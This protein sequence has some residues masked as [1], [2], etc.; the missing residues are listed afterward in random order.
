MTAVNISAATTAALTIV[1]PNGG[2]NWEA[3]SAYGP[4]YQIPTLPLL[5]IAVAFAAQRWPF[6]FKVLTVVSSA[7]MF[8]VTAHTPSVQETLPVPLANALGAFS[9]GRLD[10]P[11]LGIALGLPG[12][13]S[14]LP[15]F[16]I[17]ASL[18]LW[19]HILLRAARETTQEVAP[20]RATTT[21]SCMRNRK[22]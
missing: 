17:E 9:A 7:L 20:A 6:I 22:R 13:A 12:L 14:L 19:L 4:R 5:M 18:L 8:I 16:V 10:Q 3:G 15:L 21:N 1:A 2:E 11:N